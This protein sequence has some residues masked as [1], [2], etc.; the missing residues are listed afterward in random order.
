MANDVNVVSVLTS[1]SSCTSK[2]E[3]FIDVQD[4]LATQLETTTKQLYDTTKILEG[5]D[6]VG[7]ALPELIIDSFD[8][9]QVW[10]EIELQNDPLISSLLTSV[11]RAVASKSLTFS[12]VQRKTKTQEVKEESDEEDVEDEEAGEGREGSE[13]EDDDIGDLRF[14]QNDSDD[15]ESEEEKE[16]KR[17][18]DK[19]IAANK[20]GSE[21]DD[22]E[23]DGEMLLSDDD[24]EPTGKKS[25]QVGILKSGAASRKKQTKSKTKSVVDD[26]FFKLSDMEAFLDQEDA[27]EGRRIRQEHGDDVSSSDDDE[28]EEIDMFANIPSED[29]KESGDKKRLNYEDFFDPPS[30]V[31]EREEEEK[32]AEEWEGKKRVK[33]SQ[34]GHDSEEEAEVS[35][36]EDHQKQPRNLLDDSDEDEAMMDDVKS[37]Y[38]M[39]QQRLKKKIETMEKS[40]VSDR[41]WQLWGEIAADK[42]PENSLLQEDLDFEHTTRPAPVIT[43]ETTVKLEDLITQ[44]I[45]DQAWDDVERKVKSVD[46]P[47]EYKKR[48][49]LDQEKSKLSLGEVYEAE[50]L[51]Q[52]E[53]DEGDVKDDPQHAEIKKMMESLFV[54]LDALS[55]FHYTPKPAAPEIKIVSNQPAI[56]MEEVAPVA[57]SDTALLA[58]QEIQTKEKKELKGATERTETD[59]K[60]DLRLKKKGQRERR[61]NREHKEK[62][63]DKKKVGL[64]NKYAKERALREFEK[65][66]KVSKSVHI[67]KDDKVKK[68]LTSSKQFFGQLQEEVNA[69]I[70]NKRDQKTKKTKEND[71]S[72]TKLKL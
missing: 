10:Q 12:A 52:M 37:S 61:L 45:K 42:R 19:A 27:K 34:E 60:R 41:P 18:L 43:E 11:S 14:D 20:N 1:F 5:G 3:N 26:R 9:E 4:K 35:A 6:T 66:G 28:E 22:D 29:E 17:I 30:D 53:V 32:E 69:H 72:S 71:L 16:M 55:N 7:D 38:E 46:T 36:G 25:G 48:V 40:S 49:V 24:E 65:Q 23:D 15:D 33:F 70:R 39:R 50:Y 54:K 13:S 21:E 8:N 59:K 2:P 62:L 44:R 56:A 47:F 68:N 57:V 31:E 51:R 67:I 64:G 63:M 58:P